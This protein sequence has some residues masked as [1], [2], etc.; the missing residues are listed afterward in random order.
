MR[1]PLSFIKLITPWLLVNIPKDMSFS[2][3]HNSNDPGFGDT[4][5]V[6]L[7]HSTVHGWSGSSERTGEQGNVHVDITDVDV[8]EVAGTSVSL[9]AGVAASHS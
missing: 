9:V 5:S 8:A 3:P 6:D 4:G 7:Y 1:K 2:T